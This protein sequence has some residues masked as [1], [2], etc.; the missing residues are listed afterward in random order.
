MHF[1]PGDDGDEILTPANGGTS[2][3]SN[4]DGEAHRGLTAGQAS[5]MNWTEPALRSDRMCWS[6]VGAAH[7]LAHEL[8]LFGSFVCTAQAVST[9]SKR[10]KRLLYVYITQTSGRLGLASMYPSSPG[11]SD[12]AYLQH[13][14]FY[15][16]P[17]DLQDEDTIV[18]CW[19]DI[20]SIMRV[21]NLRLFPSKDETTDLIRSGEYLELLTQFQ[22]L[23]RSWW[24]KFEKLNLPKYPRIILTIEYEYARVYMNSLPL[25]AVLDQ[26]TSNNSPSYTQQLSNLYRRNE[27]YVREVVNSSRNL[28]KQVVEGL[29]PDEYLKHVPVRTFF[30]VLSGAMFLLK[31]CSSLLALKCNILIIIVLSHS[32]SAPKRTTLRH[33]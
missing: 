9:R 21:S 2:E 33:P 1:P 14:L 23:L 28:L 32:L 5:V 22:P 6:L 29:L 24:T 12:F 31:V 18:S 26:W 3:N 19:V 17:R 8:G 4:T 30:R 15:D 16:K 25:Q 27:I 11:E 7:T 13:T 20:A 10:L